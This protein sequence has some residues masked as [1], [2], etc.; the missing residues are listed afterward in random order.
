MTP[1]LLF[2]KHPA[3]SSHVQPLSSRFSYLIFPQLCELAFRAHFTDR[4]TGWERGSKML[5][6]TQLGLAG[7][8]VSFPQHTR[9]PSNGSRVITEGAYS[10]F[11]KI[12]IPDPTP[13]ICA[14]GLCLENVCFN[15]L[16]EP[17][18]YQESVDGKIQ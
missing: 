3:S 7:T 6:V 15:K 16:W 14:V 11:R 2:C 17:V 8:Q 10:N 12:Q 4:E 5:K 18:P 1:T 13:G 9:F